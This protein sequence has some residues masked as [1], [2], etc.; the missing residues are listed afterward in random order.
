MIASTDK[1]ARSAVMFVRTTRVSS[2]ARWTKEGAPL[3][4]RSP[5]HCAAVI[6]AR[7]SGF[8]VDKMPALI[9]TLCP[10][11][12]EIVP[13]TRPPH[14]YGLVQHLPH[15]PKQSGYGLHVK[16]IGGLIRMQP[17][18]EENLIGIDVSDSRN[19]LLTH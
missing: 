2:L 5:N 16:L 14:G 12:R 13:H 9:P 19:H 18:T 7:L 10:I 3:T 15:D 11:G 1:G 17:G 8:C 6:R 4:G